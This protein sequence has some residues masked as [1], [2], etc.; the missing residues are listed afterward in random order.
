VTRPFFTHL[1]GH[2]PS[3]AEGALLNH[4]A[5][6]LGDVQMAVRNAKLA[7]ARGQNMLVYAYPVHPL[8]EFEPLGPNTPETALLLA[9]ARQESE[10]NVVTTSGAGA[11][12]L[13]QVMDIT[14]R[15]VCKDYKIK[16]ELDRL[17][18]DA[19]YNTR[20]A[21]AYVGDRMAEFDGSYV[22]AIAGYNAGPS[23]SR[24]WARRHGDPR[25]AKVDVV[26]W[27]ERIP[28]QETREYVA[29][30]L[31]NVQI[32]RARLGDDARAL[33]LDLDLV[34]PRAPTRGKPG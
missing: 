4:L 33:Q 21:A 18:G 6:R 10:F 16:C 17:L 13:L 24:T 20:I 30:V 25:E 5:I 7:V 26:D 12:G 22:M 32:Y 29:K 34:R 23:R 1:R 19:P 15:H 2:L 28:F 9:I 8:P 31:S 14:A 3:E 27:I 11:K